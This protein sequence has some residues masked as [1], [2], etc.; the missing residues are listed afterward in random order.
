MTQPELNKAVRQAVRA[1]ERAGKEVGEVVFDPDGGGP[2]P[3]RDL[4]EIFLRLRL[5]RSC[6]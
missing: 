5:P 4:A 6:N 1:V 2:A 3:Q